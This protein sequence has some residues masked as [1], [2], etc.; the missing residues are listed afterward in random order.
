MT[1]NII[2]AVAL[3]GAIGRGDALLWHL[4]ADMKYFKATTMGHPVIMGRKTFESIGR[5]LPGR[6]NVVISRGEPSLPEGVVLV[7]SLEEALEAVASHHEDASQAPDPFIIGGGQIYSQAISLA[8]KK[9]LAA[10][11][12][13]TRVFDS[14][15]DA[16]TFFPAIEADFWKIT[17][18][19]E[20]QK[21]EASGIGFRFEQYT[22][23]R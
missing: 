4:P 12:H 18:Q 1:L 11:M 14:P 9:R 5:A 22:S 6:L 2:A 13:I 17:S 3:N 15:S 10:V 19:G 16:D 7:H 8:R 21:D 20:M 23:C